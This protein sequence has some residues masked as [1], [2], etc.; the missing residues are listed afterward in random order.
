MTAFGPRCFATCHYTFSFSTF[1][2][3]WPH[4]KKFFFSIDKYALAFGA[5]SGM[6]LKVSETFCGFKWEYVELHML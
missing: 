4:V 6:L 2:L 5:I 1:L 3:T